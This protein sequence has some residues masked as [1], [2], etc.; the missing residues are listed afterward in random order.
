[1]PRFLDLRGPESL[2][3][4]IE[5]N[6]RDALAEDI[7]PVDHTGNLVP[8][9]RNAVARVT[10]KQDTVICGAPWFDACMHALDPAARITWHVGDGESAAT[11]DTVCTVEANAR[12]ILAAERPA[13]NFLQTLS[14]TASLTARFVAAIEGVSPNPRGC[15]ILDT[16][17]TLPGLRQAQKY[18][19]RTGGGSNHR[20]GL[21]DGVLIKENH[22]AACG[23]IG[24]ALRAA[25]QS[26]KG[27]PVQI[28]VEDLEELEEALRQG[29]RSV[30]LDDFSLDDMHRG[31]QL[32][33]GRAML[34]VS[35]GVSLK[36]VRAIAATG[37]DRI[38][39]GGLTKNVDA[40]DFSM[41]LD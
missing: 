22:I 8:E 13:L 9:S 12:A 25:G 20:M 11:G 41:R 21:W 6:V 36:S 10:A 28:E 37:V 17:K 23:G 18:A 40:A 15:Q 4:A 1:M 38:S 16:R 26:A 32:A 24:A 29:A 39:I 34:E 31:F 5:R 2:A 7:G 30:L 14:A 33:G 27:V 19:V 3:A 35:G